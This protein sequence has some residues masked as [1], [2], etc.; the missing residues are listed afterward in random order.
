MNCMADQNQLENVEY[1]NYLDS[2]TTNDER[3]KHEINCRIV[4]AKVRQSVGRLVSEYS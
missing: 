2:M 3:S 4:M 1:C